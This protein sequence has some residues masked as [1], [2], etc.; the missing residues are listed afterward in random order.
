MSGIFLSYRRVDSE[1][2]SGR[3][4][5]W[6]VAEYGKDHVFTDVDTIP[7]GVDFKAYIEDW[8]GRCDC[9]LA[10]IGPQWLQI[11]DSD[12]RRRLNDPED[13][14]RAEIEAA[15]NRDIPVI[16]LLVQKAQM[17]SADELPQTLRPLALR[18][19]MAVRSGVD[20]SAD[21]HRLIKGIAPY[22]RVRGRS[23]NGDGRKPMRRRI[24][25]A[26]VALLPLVAL[27]IWLATRPSDRPMDLPVPLPSPPED[28]DSERDPP[29]T[30]TPNWATASAE[31]RTV[32]GVEY[33]EVDFRQGLTA[34]DVCSLV[35]QA[36][37]RY[38]TDYRVCQAFYPQASVKTAL[39]G[40]RAVV[41]C[42]GDE[43]EG[44]CPEY[45]DAC[46]VCPNCKSGVE[47]G[48]WGGKLYSRMF[49]SCEAPTGG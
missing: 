24:V 28:D 40:D 12:G 18:N 44:I 30:K 9:L 23:D 39:S 25:L 38:T 14:V 45:R 36:A 46:V 10:V 37:G 21:M 15:L 49:T 17:P 32:D 20:F 16:P 43:H 7:L 29:L 1:D 22:T 33:Y 19:S 8:V 35:N 2:V 11:A 34:V 4:R 6:L 48:E 3:I 27:S 13:F 42:T 41:F 47:P 26:G 31:V 5:D